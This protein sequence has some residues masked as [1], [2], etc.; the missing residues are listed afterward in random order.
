MPTIGLDYAGAPPAPYAAWPSEEGLDLRLD[1]MNLH[2]LRTVLAHGARLARLDGPVTLMAN[3]LVDSTDR[4]GLEALARL[5][6]MALSR[7][8][9]L[10][11]DFDALRPGETYRARRS[12][13]RGP[14]Q[15][16][17]RGRRGPDRCGSRYRA[18]HRGDD[19]R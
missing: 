15:G 2:E 19:A 8:G 16:R 12:A 4:R 17:R 10:Y 5:A 11:A 9:R 14:A 13:R 18:Q 6:R 3:H 1:W 7:G